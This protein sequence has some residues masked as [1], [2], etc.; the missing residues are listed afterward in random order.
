[1]VMNT[2]MINMTPT[3]SFRLRERVRC[4]PIWLP[5][6]IRDMS[7]PSVNNPMPTISITAPRKKS[8]SVPIGTGASVKLSSSTMAVMGSTELNDSRIFSFNL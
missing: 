8:P 4:A 2:P 3:I 5:I 7:A 6:C 1:M